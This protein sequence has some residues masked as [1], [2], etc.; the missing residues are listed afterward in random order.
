MSYVDSNSDP[1]VVPLNHAMDCNGFPSGPQA[2][3]MPTSKE[4]Q[5]WQEQDYSPASITGATPMSSSWSMQDAF[6]P[7]GALSVLPKETS[8]TTLHN[9][10]M[11]LP[12]P[13]MFPEGSWEAMD[14]ESLWGNQNPSLP[15]KAA[16]QMTNMPLSTHLSLPTSPNISSRVS[17]ARHTFS[18]NQQQST[19]FNHL[20]SILNKA[21][22]TCTNSHQNCLSSALATLQTLHIPPTNCLSSAVSTNPPIPIPTPR[23]TDSVLAINRAAVQRVS[24]IIRCTCIDSSQMQLILVVICEKLIAWYQALLRSF[25]GPHDIRDNS[26]STSADESTERVLHQHFALGDC[27]FGLELE[28]SIFA[29]V[30]TAELQQ[31]EIVIRDLETRLRFLNGQGTE[32]GTGR[33]GHQFVSTIEL[34][35][36]L[37]PVH[38]QLTACIL[39]KVV[40]LKDRIG[41]DL[42]R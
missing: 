39:A 26:T 30:M 38:E 3:G 6:H 12:N 28:S 19:N 29:Q 2:F 11:S 5:P 10:H 18:A 34:P 36:S 41:G 16:Q 4:S 42:G 15:R 13:N 27:S 33:M 25:P 7:C 21:P 9:Q 24:Q 35:G 40:E 17:T 32:T 20:P 22:T 14:F 31:F 1:L 23:K 37:S 8:A